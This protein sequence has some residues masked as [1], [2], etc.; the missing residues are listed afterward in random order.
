M[1]HSQGTGSDT[2]WSAAESSQQLAVN[3]SPSHLVHAVP[4]DV[5]VSVAGAVWI[6]VVAMGYLVGRGVRSRRS[7]AMEGAGRQPRMF[8]GIG[9]QAV[10]ALGGVAV[11]VYGLWGF[12]TD[13]KLA[14][15]PGLLAVG[16]IGVFD[17]SEMVLF[18]MLYKAADKD[19]G[20]TPEL[21][22]MHKTAWVLVAFSASMN[23]VHAHTWWGRPIL[24]AVPV[25]AAWLIELQLRAKLQKTAEDED[26]RPGPIRLVQLSWQHF[27]AWVFVQLRLDATAS[28]G[29]INRAAR[30]QQAAARIYQLRLALEPA[31]ALQAKLD[32]G[33]QLSRTEAKQLAEAMKQ[34]VPLR[35]KAQLAIDSSDMATDSS[36]ALA[37][38]RRFTSLVRVDDL[39]L[40]D[41]ADPQKQ[42]SIMEEVAVIPAA[43]LIEASARAAE[44]EEKAARSAAARQEAER[45]RQR[46]QEALEKILAE[47]RRAQ[48][49]REDAE[50]IA[51]KAKETAAEAEAEA[52]RSADARLEAERARQRSADEISELS[53]KAAVLRIEAE[54]EEKR[55]S[56]AADKRAR[57]EEAGLAVLGK[58]QTLEADLE[59]VRK[60]LERLGSARQEA[61]DATERA[62]ADA[63]RAEERLRTMEGRTKELE[64]DLRA[65]AESAQEAADL[66]LNRQEEA[67]FWARV[68]DD[69]SAEAEARRLAAQEA[70]TVL[71]RLRE[72]VRELLPADTVLPTEVP[73]FTGS[74]GKQLA[75]EEYLKAV[76]TGNTPASAAEVAAATGNAESTVRN[77]IVEFRRTR[78][79]MIA[80]G[81]PSGTE[82]RA[83][84]A[85]RQPS[86]STGQPSSSRTGAVEHP[87]ENSSATLIAGQRQAV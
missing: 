70:E 81:L 3:L 77:W 32:R 37:M 60:E 18:G 7:A 13:P 26:S 22:L 35:K 67:R 63:N 52:A 82:Q 66:V 34:I 45:A 56:D 1:R 29:R 25:L 31:L 11:S 27:W 84:G 65:R 8:S 87:Q 58:K 71:A 36:Q 40:L 62:I 6:A 28:N 86:A 20:W 61:A 23:A 48:S 73:V 53:Q 59:A 9:P 47:Q 5:L 42:V 49:A 21:R 41:C 14:G 69:H 16:L 44:E 51:R 24:A 85:E 54:K 74:A 10:V 50:E 39:A 57:Q 43:R 55:L 68:V 15:L 75:W 46:E 64:A 78:D 76:S 80:A 4:T 33:D 38:M 2:H 30:A 83:S 79:R 19:T 72:E 12:A 17:A